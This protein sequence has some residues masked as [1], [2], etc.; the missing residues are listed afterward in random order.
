MKKR[1]LIV[2]SI[3]LGVVFVPYFAGFIPII[4]TDDF[5][6]WVIGIVNLT[7]IFAALIVIVGAVQL[8]I[9][10]VNYIKNGN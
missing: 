1:L 6:V 4:P 10:A 3:A 7:I 5:P 8:V 9:F 2:I